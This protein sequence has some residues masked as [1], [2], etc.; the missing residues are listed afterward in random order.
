MNKLIQ[1][2]KGVH[3]TAWHTVHD[4]Y[5]ADAEVAR[6]LVTT[7]RQVAAAAQPDAIIDLGGGTGFLLRRVLAEGIDHGTSLINLDDS[8]AQ[9]R[10][11]RSRGITCLHG[12]VEAFSRHAA[13]LDRTRCLFIMRSVLHYF[14][15]RGL[16][17]V[18][19]GLRAQARPGEFFVHQT[20][21]FRRTRDAAC[22][23]DLYTMMRTPKWYPA[24]AALSTSLRAAG[25][26]VLNISPAPPLRLTSEDL[27]GRYQLAAAE[28][29]RIRER[30]S[31]ARP[32]PDVFH[33]TPTGFVAHLH[34]WTY[35]CEPAEPG[36][37]R[38]P[39]VYD[40]ATL[41]LWAA[42]C[43]E[44]VLPLFVKWRKKDSRPREAIEA[45]RAWARGEIK[46]GEARKAALAAH[47]AARAATHHGESEAAA[48]AAGHAAATA[49]MPGHARHAA[50]YAV[51]ATV[52]AEG[53]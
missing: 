20:A 34:Y 8:S 5:F 14:G 49:H 21:S 26:N 51:K 24:V 32:P 25:W 46:C 12:S 17:R 22:L 40:Q 35:L 38:Q 11:A 3:G 52:A 23:N 41:A 15:Q 44:E 37:R 1:R 4:G 18:L 31:A 19:R 53:I 16:G 29:C 33:A 9:L 36:T 48:R 39:D 28:I 30:C 43:A 6:P 7:I 42:D 27:A 45:A 13:G 2:E 10:A 50:H 47:A